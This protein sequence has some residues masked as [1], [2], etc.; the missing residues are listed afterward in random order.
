MTE[1]EARPRG[2][3]QPAEVRRRQILDAL[4]RLAVTEGL[5]TVTIA[6]VAEE[7]GIAKGS[8]YLHYESRAELVAALQTDVWERMLAEPNAVAAEESMTWTQRLDRILEHW[9]AFEFDNHDLYHAVFHVAGAGGPEPMEQAR[10]LLRSVLDGGNRA[11]E[12]D[13]IDIETTTEFLLHAYGGPCYHSTDRARVTETLL[14][15]FHRTISAPR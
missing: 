1:D 13:V 9:I 14:A 10:H 6:R 8:I 15:L 3:F 12:F 4:A 11:G 7:A 2:R 5:D